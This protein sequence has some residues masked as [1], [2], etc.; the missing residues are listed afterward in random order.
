MSNLFRFLLLLTFISCST[1]PEYTYFTCGHG[2]NQSDQVRLIFK[3]KI[4]LLKLSST[5]EGFYVDSIRVQ[6]GVQ[7]FVSKIIYPE[8]AKRAGVEGINGVSFTVDTLGNAIDIKLIKGI[9]AGCD[10]ALL[11]AIKSQKFVYQSNFSEKFNE[12]IYLLVRFKLY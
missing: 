8:I 1:T 3:D 7:S 11:M 4:E 5:P 12:R 2:S 9:G 6:G 10:E